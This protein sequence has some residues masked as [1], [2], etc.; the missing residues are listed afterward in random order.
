MGS[1]GAIAVA[2]SNV[3]VLYAG[4]GEVPIRSVTIS[5]GDGVYK[6]TD[7]G[8]TWAHVG[9]KKPV[10]FQKLKWL[11]RIWIQPM[12][13]YKDKYGVTILSAE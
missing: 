13:L 7:A 5:H 10:K 9:L 6:S 11:I 12:L 8:K 2:P 3:N 4:T 1:I